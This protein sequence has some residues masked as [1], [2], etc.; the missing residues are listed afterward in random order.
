MTN[1]RRS[2]TAAALV[3]TAALAAGAVV[4]VALEELLYRRVMR[5]PDPEEHE[6]IG[7]ITGQPVQA[8]AFDGTLLNGS[9]YGSD[10]PALTLVFVHGAIESR[11]LWHYQVRDLCSDP[12]LRLLAYDA[13][14]HGLSGPARGPDG[15]TP[16][17]EYSQCRD[18]VAVVDQLTTGPV[19]IVGHSMGGMA[20]LALWQHGEIQH[21]RDRVVGIVLVNSAYTADLRGWRGK[22][23]RRERAFERAEDVL[24]RIPMPARLLDRVRPGSSDLTLVIGRLAYGT[25]PSPT[26]IATSVAMYESTPSDT[27]HAFIDL[28]RFDAHGALGLVDVPALVIAGSKDFI[29]PQMLS[30]EIAAHVADAELVVLEGC[31]HVGPFERHEDVS[32]HLRKFVDRVS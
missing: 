30:E 11:L 7:A 23:K 2:R 29:T 25:D 18:L 8:V 17:T 21:I 10:H 3:G 1:E 16:F 6:P 12:G 31:G 22:G 13:R 14:G 15:E 28:T 5:R 4:G 24:Q 26:H 19:V 9:A 27:L 32:A 20:T